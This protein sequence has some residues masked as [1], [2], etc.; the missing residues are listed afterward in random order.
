MP[1][2][3]NELLS[4]YRSKYPKYVNVS[5]EELFS[6]IQK[7]RPEEAMYAIYQDRGYDPD[8]GVVGSVVG[9]FGRGLGTLLSGPAKA[10]GILYSAITPEEDRAVDTIAYQVGEWLDRKIAQMLPVNPEY[11]QKFMTGTLPQAAGSMAGFLL[12]GG[13]SRGIAGAFK[14][15]PKVANYLI[16]ALLGSSVGAPGM[17]EDAIRMGADEGTA[18]LAA[19]LG[20]AIGLTEAIPVGRILGKVDDA[21]KGSVTAALARRGIT[22]TK[23]LSKAKNL[24]I[25]RAAGIEGIEELIQESTQSFLENA[26]ARELYDAHRELTDGTFEGGLAGF[27]TGALAAAA[28]VKLGHIRKERMDLTKV[29]YDN[30]I[31]DIFVKHGKEGDKMPP[32]EI[33]AM[34]DFI[35]NVDDFYKEHEGL[36]DAQLEKLHEERIIPLYK[37]VLKSDIV[38]NVR[39]KKGDAVANRLAFL[40]MKQQVDGEINKRKAENPIIWDEEI[41]KSQQEFRNKFSLKEEYEIEKTVNDIDQVVTFDEWLEDRANPAYIEIEKERA[42]IG[43]D[44]I[45][46]KTQGGYTRAELTQIAKELDIEVGKKTKRELARDITRARGIQAY[47]SLEAQDAQKT[48]EV[49]KEGEAQRGTGEQGVG[50]MRQGDRAETAQEGEQEEEVVKTP[51]ETAQDMAEASTGARGEDLTEKTTEG[52]PK[53]ERASKASKSVDSL[54]D[55]TR[56]DLQYLSR[57]LGKRYRGVKTKA[58]L[59]KRLEKDGVTV[60]EARKKLTKANALKIKS[61]KQFLRTELNY[62]IDVVENMADVEIEEA[63]KRGY[64]YENAQISKKHSLLHKKLKQNRLFDFRH[65]IYKDTVGKESTENFTLEDYDK[66]IERI[67]EDPDLLPAEDALKDDEGFKVAYS[68]NKLK[69]FWEKTKHV[70]KRS[71]NSIESRIKSDSGKKTLALFQYVIDR[72]HQ[73]RGTM[74]NLDPI[75]HLL[76]SDDGYILGRLRGEIA[77]PNMKKKEEE[78]AVFA[79]KW[80]LTDPLVQLNKFRVRDGLEPIKFRKNYFPQVYEAQTMSKLISQVKSME[81][82]IKD[83]KTTPARAVK[84]FLNDTTQKNTLLYKTLQFYVGK[85][86]PL[87]QAYSTTSAIVDAHIQEDFLLPEVEEQIRKN[88]LKSMKAKE[89]SFEKERKFEIVP[90]FLLEN[91][92]GK[93]V[94]RYVDRMG[95]RVALADVFGVDGK[96][97]AKYMDEVRKESP[98]DA[99]LLHKTLHMMDGRYD[100]SKGYKGTARKLINAFYAIE[101]GTK[102]GLGTA[103]IP[104]VVQPLYSSAMQGGFMRTFG[105]AIKTL[106]SPKYR[107]F[108]S[109]SGIIY[110]PAQYIFLGHDDNSKLNKISRAIGKLAFEPINRFNLYISAGT[111]DSLVTDRIPKLARAMAKGQTKTSWF[112]KNYDLM[113]EFGFSDGDIKGG[114]RGLDRYKY[115]RLMQRF[116]RN[117]QLQKNVLREAEMF[118]EPKLR[119]FLL[120]KRFGYGQVKLVKDVCGNALKRGDIMPLLRFALAGAFGGE[121]VWWAKNMIKKILS[122]EE[123]YRKETNITERF[124]SNVAIA[125]SWGMISDVLE[126]TDVSNLPTKIR[127]LVEPVIVQDMAKIF[128]STQK[129][130]DSQKEYDEFWG[131]TLPTA[132]QEYS[133]LFGSMPRYAMLRTYNQAQWDNRLKYKRG[134]QRV[135][136]LDLI[137]EGKSKRAI[138]LL[139]RWN[140]AHP[141]AVFTYDDVNHEEVYKHKI[142][143][144]KRIA[145][146]LVR[147]KS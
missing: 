1:S 68:S 84:A 28:G 98:E 31:D 69:D 50:D 6:A 64:T 77:E 12:G 26:T 118:G 35:D 110:D 106:I 11:E 22:G 119:P 135:E 5:D 15:S 2:A 62:P 107:H 27:I 45:K 90:D 142:E 101:Y 89:V 108:L 143:K 21:T 99:K 71:I 86:L 145:E 114:L 93:V 121:F 63:V 24:E 39:E 85:G 103:F 38:K 60:K 111:F 58:D 76:E 113:K 10:G 43:K 82:Y 9:S 141:D 80:I 74:A 139:N 57:V 109:K 125:G 40:L 25:L 70:V 78:K 4:Y 54:N 112:R 52:T 41:Q 120:F 36:N 66:V 49:R 122:G 97:F 126:I 104:N 20:G 94:T 19:A 123:D 105:S 115:E 72:H 131:I 37:T 129:V 3:V 73:F 137:A 67:A 18:Q 100:R 65:E 75:M 8:T 79:I 124:L 29:G 117:M 92:I 61:P 32:P 127:F 30:A 116:A 48:D 53:K 16:P 34:F 44:F 134:Q 56:D 128:E 23:A 7:H 96:K 14:L 102:I 95:L 138:V 144:E 46:P 146:R 132:G 88:M 47:N 55:I 33:V 87:S 130:F 59:V 140:E 51:Q 42:N 81:E 17:Y 147:R 91:D 83:R 136:I 13:I 133:G